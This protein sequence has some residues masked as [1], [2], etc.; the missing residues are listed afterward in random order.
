MVL[1]LLVLR[2]RQ[3]PFWIDILLAA[4]TGG[5]FTAIAVQAWAML[6]QTNALAEQVRLT[7]YAIYR[8]YREQAKEVYCKI[9]G[10]SGYLKLILPQIRDAI[11]YNRQHGDLG[12]LSTLKELEVKLRRKAQEYLVLPIEELQKKIALLPS[13]A[14]DDPLIQEIGKLPDTLNKIANTLS[15]NPQKAKSELETTKTTLETLVNSLERD[16]ALTERD[17]PKSFL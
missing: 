4:V 16:Y 8:Q 13:F 5:S 17:C 6:K 3:S 2:L 11:E 15:Q 7:R 12:P 9:R 10:I 1:G 14:P